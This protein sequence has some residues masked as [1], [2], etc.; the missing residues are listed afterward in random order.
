MDRREDPRNIRSLQEFSVNHQFQPNFSKVVRHY[1]PDR[2]GDFVSPA[3]VVP[4]F[5]LARLR[6]ARSF[7]MKSTQRHGTTAVKQILSCDRR[8][9]SRAVGF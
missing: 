7:L 2:C 1:V 8:G 4:L 5:F 6:P 3:F 9:S